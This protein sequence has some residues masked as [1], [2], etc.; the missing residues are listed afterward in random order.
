MIV[1]VWNC[2]VIV[3]LEQS[4]WLHA[5]LLKHVYICYMTMCLAGVVADESHCTSHVEGRYDKS[6]RD[7]SLANQAEE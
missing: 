4:V 7:V 6:S 5:L 1:L 2:V 3:D